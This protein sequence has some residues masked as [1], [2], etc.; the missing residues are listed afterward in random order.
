MIP[1]I[2]NTQDCYVVAQSRPP[3]DPQQDWNLI[4]VENEDGFTTLE[5]WR[6]L[7]TCDDNDRDIEVS[8]S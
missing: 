6:K 8:K 3:I 4:R 7:V 1:C 5:F 2:S